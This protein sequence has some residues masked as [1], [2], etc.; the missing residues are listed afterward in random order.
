MPE[1][2]KPE[3][4][5]QLHDAIDLIFDGPTVGQESSWAKKVTLGIRQ[6]IVAAGRPFD[7]I[8]GE[9]LAPVAVPP[10]VIRAAYRSGDD[11]P[12]YD[13]TLKLP[14]DDRWEEIGRKARNDDLSVEERRRVAIAFL[15]EI[16][17]STHP[18]LEEIGAAMDAL[19]FGEVKAILQPSRKGLHGIGYGH[20]AWWLRL[21]GLQC[22]EYVFH[23]GIMSKTDAIKA[24]AEAFSRS[25]LA[26]RGGGKIRGWYEQ[27]AAETRF[28]I[29]YVEWELYCA[30]KAGQLLKRKRSCAQEEA[31]SPGA[32]Q[33]I[34]PSELIDEVFMMFE[35][36]FGLERLRDYGKQFQQLP[37]K[38][39]NK[40]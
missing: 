14:I 30:R 21:R 32:K 34:E 3:Q 2:N 35:S 26:V 5:K 38:R 8:A 17:P 20:S 39:R 27:A 24:V 1:L 22:A 6:I 31:N 4:R 9:A 16:T 29:E 37:R 40:K 11:D 36:I 25:V 10:E 19:P 33:P 28:G 15:R 13:P 18:I 12:N 23:A 7:V